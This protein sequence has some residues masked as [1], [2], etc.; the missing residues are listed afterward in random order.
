MAAN[1]LDKLPFV[2]ATRRNHSL[3]HA[4]LQVLA[5]KFHNLRMSG[6]SFARGFYL[7]VDLP[8][9]I[10]TRAALE[11]EKRLKAGESQL[12]VHPHCGTNL[13]V[14]ATVAASFAWLTW[15][16]T[17]RRKQ[18]GWVQVSLAAL[19]AVP[20]FF[21]ARPLGPIV[22]QKIMTSADIGE[23]SIRQVVSMRYGNTFFHKIITER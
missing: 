21:L 17:Q 7:N 11:A 8:T 4:T 20:A 3:E 22:Q 18:P 12:A 19:V 23:T 6:V 2:G 1:L 5:E 15:L 10:V 14:P 16:I 9:D 13:V